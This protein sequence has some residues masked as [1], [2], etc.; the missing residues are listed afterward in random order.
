MYIY[1]KKERT[2]KNEIFIR[3]KTRLSRAAE[4]SPRS[5]LTAAGVLLHKTTGLSSQE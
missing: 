5:Q 4:R 3:C 2:T 1:I